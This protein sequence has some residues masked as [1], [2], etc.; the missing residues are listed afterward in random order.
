MMPKIGSFRPDIKCPGYKDTL[1]E[2]SSKAP[3]MGRRV[4]A[5]R[6]SAGGKSTEGL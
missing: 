6:F 3:F 1:A 4:V 2:A 5:R